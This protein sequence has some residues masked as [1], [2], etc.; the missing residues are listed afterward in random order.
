MYVINDFIIYLLLAIGNV[1]QNT[2]L[3]NHMIW[4]DLTLIW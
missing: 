3:I 4:H 1:F 2:D